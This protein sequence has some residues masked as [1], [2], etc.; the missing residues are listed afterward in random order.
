MP[1]DLGSLAYRPVPYEDDMPTALAAAD[2]VVCRAGSGTLFE[3]AAA[4]LP[5]ILVP[6]PVVTADQQT[7][8]AEHLVDGRRG[9]ARARRRARRSAARCSQSTQLVDDEP[10]PRGDG[11]GGRAPGPRPDAADDIAALAEAH[12]RG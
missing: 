6:S 10:R 4:G 2:L 3:L 11:G 8:N 5:A 12:A 9:R 7:R 1:P